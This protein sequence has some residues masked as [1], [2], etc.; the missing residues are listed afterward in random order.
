MARELSGRGAS[1]T[2]FERR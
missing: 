2:L 1:V